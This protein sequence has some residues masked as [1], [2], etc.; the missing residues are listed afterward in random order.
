MSMPV[1]RTNNSGVTQDAWG[2]QTDVVTNQMYYFQLV[3]CTCNN[4]GHP[5]G[6]FSKPMQTTMPGGANIT[7]YN[8]PLTNPVPPECKPGHGH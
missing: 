1:R 3:T 8:Q 4:G 2:S 6:T 7:H 5:L